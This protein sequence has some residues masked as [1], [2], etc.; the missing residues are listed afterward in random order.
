[1]LEHPQQLRGGRVGGQ[2]QSADLL[3]L[4][5]PRFLFELVDD[6]LRA[7]VR[8][9]NCIVKWL[10]RLVV[11]D[12]RCF[13]LVGNADAFDAVAGVTLGFEFCYCVF[14]A[15]LYGSDELQRVMFMPA[16]MRNRQ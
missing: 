7:R 1:M 8:P 6:R 13:A 14:D 11:P 16:A 4:G 9:D 12:D 3:E 2:R 15:G 5:R 10:A